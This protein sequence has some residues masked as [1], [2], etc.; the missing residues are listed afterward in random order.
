[1]DKLETWRQ[2]FRPLAS[3]TLPDPVRD[4]I[5]ARLAAEPAPAPQRRRQLWPKPIAQWGSIAAAVIASVVTVSQLAAP[6]TVLPDVAPKA[7]ANGLFAAARPFSSP[8]HSTAAGRAPLRT[9]ASPV[10]IGNW[11]I[12]GP[13]VFWLTARTPSGLPRPV[14]ALP[15]LKVLPIA[16]QPRRQAVAVQIGSS[17]RIARFAYPRYFTFNRRRY[18]VTPSLRPTHLSLSIGRVGT[19]TV[20]RLHDLPLRDGVGLLS[21]WAPPITADPVR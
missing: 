20:Y 7:P 10:L 12:L 3:E 13:R 2:R 1:M 17:L 9:P 5:R 18:R 19:Y 11:L 14:K 4:Q 8:S 16:H 6:G 21:V 15:W